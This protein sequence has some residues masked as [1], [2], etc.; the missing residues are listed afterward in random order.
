[1]T[2]TKKDSIKFEKQLERLREGATVK[3]LNLFQKLEQEVRTLRTEN[4]E[5]KVLY[6]GNQAIM[7][8]L[9]KDLFELGDKKKELEEALANALAD[10][11]G[12][13]EAD[14]LMMNKLERIQELEGINE[15]HQKINGDLR[16]EITALEQEK[17]ELHVDNKKLA[18]QVDDV[19]DRLRKS[20]M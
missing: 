14:R 20:G 17:L 12:L 1:M 19:L 2:T 13:Q 16:R 10:D 15:S 9:T 5:L 3:K 4:T 7:K 8:D 6:K 11:S 18:K